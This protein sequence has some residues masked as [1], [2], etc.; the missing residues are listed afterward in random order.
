MSVPLNKA[1][2]QRSIDVLKEFDFLQS[3]LIFL[4]WSHFL[5]KTGVHPAS[6]AGQAFSGKLLLRR[7]A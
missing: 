3:A 7:D 1:T 6:S 5:R 2:I 4:S